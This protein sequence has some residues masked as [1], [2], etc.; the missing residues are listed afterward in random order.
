MGKP[1]YM[2]EI[3]PRT[4]SLNTN[5]TYTAGDGTNG[6]LKKA[7]CSSRL[8]MALFKTVVVWSQKP[9]IAYEYRN[10]EIS[11][12]SNHNGKQNCYSARESG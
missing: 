2:E 12:A 10:I 1:K 3:F 6:T 8:M 7:S 11:A 9:H 4:A 5:H